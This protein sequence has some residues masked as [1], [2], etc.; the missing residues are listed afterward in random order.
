MN[1]IIEPPKEAFYLPHPSSSERILRGT[2]GLVPDEFD[3]RRMVIVRVPS[4]C[5]IREAK[6]LVQSEHATAANWHTFAYALQPYILTELHNPGDVTPLQ[7]AP[8]SLP[9][10]QRKHYLAAFF[11]Y[12]FG[13]DDNRIQ[14]ANVCQY[15][16]R[17]GWDICVRN[18]Y[19][20]NG[21]ERVSPLHRDTIPGRRPGRPPAELLCASR[22]LLLHP[23]SEQ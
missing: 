16:L 6:A 4:E 22:L 10:D 11:W 23:G 15:Y 20:S 7:P 8:P 17:Q 5:L 19:V 12:L 3:S 2:A 14:G 18:R 21:S 9:P 1:I 13:Y